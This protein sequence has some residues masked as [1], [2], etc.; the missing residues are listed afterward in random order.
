MNGQ[1]SGPYFLARFEDYFHLPLAEARKALGIN[2]V[3]D[4]D[5]SAMADVFLEERNAA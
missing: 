5:T 1:M 3:D 2:N 4:V